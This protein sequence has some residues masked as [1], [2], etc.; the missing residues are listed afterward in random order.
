MPSEKR[1]YHILSEDEKD[2]MIAST[3]LSQERDDFSHAV[4]I[5]RYEEMLKDPTMPTK[6]RSHIEELL[7]ETRNRLAEVRTIE[8]ALEKELPT[9]ARLNS[10]V[11]RLRAKENAAQ[12]AQK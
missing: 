2:D 9:T 10:A 11:A 1:T 5:D 12:A 8:N 6:F 7:S 4:S 3:L